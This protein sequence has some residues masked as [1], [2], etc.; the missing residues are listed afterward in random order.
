[1]SDLTLHHRM[2]VE[3]SQRVERPCIWC[4]EPTALMALTPFRPD[5]GAV[6]LMLTCGVLM[7]EAYRDFLAGIV[8]EGDAPFLRHMGEAIRMIESGEVPS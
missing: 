8:D 7:R 5:L 3:P 4:G 1:M 6:P 2:P